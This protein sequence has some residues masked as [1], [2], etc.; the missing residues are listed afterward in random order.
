M[1]EL[2]YNQVTEWIRECSITILGAVFIIAL[3][4]VLEVHVFTEDG[5]ERLIETTKQEVNEGREV[6]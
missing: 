5:F 2:E 3:R 1:T 4:R 6:K